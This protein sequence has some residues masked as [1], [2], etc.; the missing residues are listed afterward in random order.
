MWK[1]AVKRDHN[2]YGKINIFSSNQRFLTKELTEELISRKL[3]ELISRKLSGKTGNS[4]TDKTL[5]NQQLV[6]SFIKPLLSR[7]FCEKNLREN[8]CNFHI[9]SVTLLSFIPVEARKLDFF[10]L[11]VIDH[12]CIEQYR[13]C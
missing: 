1:I 3:S 11:L 7:N 2:F 5:S 9:V 6:I 8:F 12:H 4:L 10:K 13:K